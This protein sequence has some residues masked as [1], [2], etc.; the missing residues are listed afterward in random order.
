MDLIILGNKENVNSEFPLSS[1]QYNYDCGGMDFINLIGL[2]IKH[3]PYIPPNGW[4]ILKSQKC[5]TPPYKPDWDT[6]IYNDQKWKPLDDGKLSYD[7]MCMINGTE[8]IARSFVVHGFVRI[9]DGLSVVI[10]GAHYSH[11]HTGNGKDID[12]QGQEISFIKT[13]HEVMRN[14]NTTNFILI[15]DTNEDSW[16]AKDNLKFLKIYNNVSDIVN[17]SPRRFYSC[18]QDDGYSYREDKIIADFGNE[19]RSEMLYDGISAKNMPVWLISTPHSI[20][21][22]PILATLYL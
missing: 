7:E 17:G 20:S 10:A 16:T 21:H 13:I 11:D 22:K 9:S 1:M 12:I 15:A 14:I 3:Y 2:P 19:M 6:L 18:C 4:T 5:G 8:Y